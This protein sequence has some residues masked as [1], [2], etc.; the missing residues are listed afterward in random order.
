[1]EPRYEDMIPPSSALT[2]S[3]A[4]PNIYTITQVSQPRIRTRELSDLSTRNLRRHWSPSRQPDS[5]MSFP[6]R[7]GRDS[8]SP[9]SIPAV[10]E[11]TL[12]SASLPQPAS[13]KD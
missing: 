4:L 3:R 13:T 9:A 7:D 8:A 6:L 12:S 11:T 10:A 2:E 1:M 5:S